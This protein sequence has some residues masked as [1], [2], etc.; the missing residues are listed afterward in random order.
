MILYKDLIERSSGTAEPHSFFLLRS[1]TRLGTKWHV[2]YIWYVAFRGGHGPGDV[3]SLDTYHSYLYLRDPTVDIQGLILFPF[4]ED[5]DLE[6]EEDDL[7]CH[8]LVPG[9]L[10][11]FERPDLKSKPD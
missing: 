7:I 9:I 4:I 3:R 11:K 5:S 6:F 8:W 1:Q 10:S 2:D